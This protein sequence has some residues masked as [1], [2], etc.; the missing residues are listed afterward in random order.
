MTVVRALLRAAVVVLCLLALGSAA[1]AEGV[2]VVTSRDLPAYEQ[3][4]AG[5]AAAMS[6]RGV[7]LHFFNLAETSP[8]A[9][10]QA[11]RSRGATAVFAI[12]TEAAQAALRSNLPV[13]FSMVVDHRQ[14]GLTGNCT[15][16]ILK[17]PVAD[18]FKVLKAALPKAKDV[19]VLYNPARSGAVVREAQAA[20][21]AFGLR[22]HPVEV[23]SESALPRAVEKMRGMDV[24]WATVDSTVYASQPAKFILQ[25]AL[26]NG[27]PV[28]G[29]SANMV[30]AGALFAAYPDFTDIGRQGAVLVGRVLSGESAGAIPVADP[31]KVATAVNTRVADSLPGVSLP[32][33][34]RKQ[35]DQRY[36]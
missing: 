36:P 8:T 23:T 4:R 11:M 10:A 26:R 3:A 35:A 33:A 13:V 31:G 1:R 6:H 17:L 5:F 24:I 30:E 20:A 32:A 2:A 34:F 7:K 14:A 21:P 29:F 18:Q 25:F 22:L 19:G 27:I 28:M 15:G 12:G 16:V 9:L